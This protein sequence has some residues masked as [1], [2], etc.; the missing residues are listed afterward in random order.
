VVLEYAALTGG[1]PHYVYPQHQLVRRLC[2]ALIAAGGQ[3]RFGHAVRAVRQDPAGVVLSVDGPGGDRSQVRCQAAAGCEGSVSP[4]A[5]AMTE[6]RVNGQPLPVRLLVI[7]GAAPPLQPHTIYAAHPRGFAGQMR[8]GPDQTRYF[9]EIPGTD[10]AADWPEQRA[11][12]ELAARLG[13]GARLDRVPLGEFGLLDMRVRMIEPMQQDRLF[14]AGDAAHLITPAGAKGMNLA[15]Q[16]A[17]ELAHGLIERFGP[18]NDERRLSA[19]SRT[20]LP[21]IWRA[22][23]FSNWFL[24]LILTSLQDGPEL[25]AAVPGGFADGLRQAWIAAL[26]NDPSFARWFAHAYAGVDAG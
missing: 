22:Q 4:V 6:A 23:A 8:R 17:V 26:Q 15:I 3:V 24:H 13:V 18:G 10:T 5:A 16:D 7:L 21:H 14:L 9:L 25:P 2:E 20:R 1:R 12:G 19:Y 11:R